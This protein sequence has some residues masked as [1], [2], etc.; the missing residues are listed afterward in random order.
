MLFLYDEVQ[1]FP[2][3]F[4]IRANAVIPNSRTTKNNLVI[5]S[6]K[7]PFLKVLK[8]K[9]VNLQSLIYIYLIEDLRF[10]ILEFCLNPP[11]NYRSHNCARNYPITC[12]DQYIFKTA[13]FV[14]SCNSK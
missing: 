8:S 2:L 3:D 7:A 4:K 6:C 14:Q 12:G 10:L 9:I 13:T 11:T 5:V 1:L